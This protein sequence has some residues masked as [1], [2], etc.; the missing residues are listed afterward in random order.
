MP[1]SAD[2]FVDTTVETPNLI[3]S[4]KSIPTH[5]PSIDTTRTVCS[6]RLHIFNKS[7]YVN[8]SGIMW[9]LNIL[10][11]RGVLLESCDNMTFDNRVNARSLGANIVKLPPLFKVLS[12][13]VVLTAALNILNP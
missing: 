8:F 11:S 9:T 6:P 13:S 2:I 1:L 3:P 4:L 12:S 5:E 7:R 10:V